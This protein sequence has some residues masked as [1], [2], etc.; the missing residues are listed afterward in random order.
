MGSQ[1]RFKAPAPQPNNQENPLWIECWPGD[2]LQAF[3]IKNCKDLLI[4][5]GAGRVLVKNQ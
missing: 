1:R 3:S 2:F 5:E 4:L